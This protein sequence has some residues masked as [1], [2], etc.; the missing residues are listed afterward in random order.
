M[1]EDN[2]ASYHRRPPQTAKLAA[3]ADTD[4]LCTLRSEWDNAS[5]SSP[6]HEDE[7]DADSFGDMLAD[8]D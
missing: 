7:R 3:T 5:A 6:S 4:L 1:I 8:L 2:R